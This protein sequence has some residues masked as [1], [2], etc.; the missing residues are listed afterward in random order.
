M[1]N[2]IIGIKKQKTIYFT[3]ISIEMIER[4]IEDIINK[5][6]CDGKAIIFLVRELIRTK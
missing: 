2:Q 4:I 5:K 6:L 3:E 1:R